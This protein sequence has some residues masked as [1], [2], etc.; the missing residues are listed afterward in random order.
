MKFLDWPYDYK[1]RFQRDKT[2]LETGADEAEVYC[3][4]FIYYS[5]FEQRL[6][7]PTQTIFGVESISPSD[8]LKSPK[9]KL[10]AKW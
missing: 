1:F 10:V 7:I 6:E 3:S 4:E 8:F 9:L 2:E 5:D